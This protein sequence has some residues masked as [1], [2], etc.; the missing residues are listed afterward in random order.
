MTHGSGEIRFLLLFC[1]GR[2]V[3]WNGSPLWQLTKANNRL[4]LLREGR[5]M[6]RVEV[7]VGRIDF[8][9]S[10][11]RL[12]TAEQSKPLNSRVFIL[13]FSSTTRINI[14]IDA[15]QWKSIEFNDSM[16]IENFQRVQ[17]L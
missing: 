16:C 9:L 15:S 8:S 7:G 17:H 4:N 13:L 3:S 1:V 2:I 14:W 6:L 12:N 11:I 5:A 10:E